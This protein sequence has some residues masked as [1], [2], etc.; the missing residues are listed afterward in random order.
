[1]SRFRAF[2]AII[3]TSSVARNS[4]F[5]IQ[6]SVNLLSVPARGLH[7][8]FF[9]TITSEAGP[10]LRRQFVVQTSISI[11]G[12]QSAK[13]FEA[14]QGTR[15]LSSMQAAQPLPPL[16]VCVVGAGSI[17]REFALYHFNAATQTV[18]TGIVDLDEDRARRLA[19]DVGS[20]QAG[21][22][23]KNQGAGGAYS[24]AASHRRGTPVPFATRLAPCLGDCDVVYIGTTPNSHA[25]LVIEALEAGKSVLMEKPLASTARDADAIVAAAE[26]AE[27]RGQIVGMDIGM[28]W[29]VSRRVVLSCPQVCLCVYMTMPPLSGIPLCT[30]C[31]AWQ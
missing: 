26:Q 31:A 18:V 15:P 1:M 16:R 28:R 5:T 19:I 10:L 17:S 30:R 20:V 24:A 6:P 22:S 27:E 14:R 25:E 3:L 21:A 12:A 13:S 29:Y 2:F 8:P 11:A 23:I 9:A 7:T 4:A